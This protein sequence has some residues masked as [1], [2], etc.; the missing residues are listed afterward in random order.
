MKR[1][2]INGDDAMLVLKKQQSMEAL[3][4]LVGLSAGVFVSWPRKSP[5][6]DFYQLG[7]VN[8]G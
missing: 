8:I 3:R 1:K 5:L 4:V 7:L 2:C 6:K